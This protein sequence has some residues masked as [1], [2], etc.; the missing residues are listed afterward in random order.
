MPCP[1]PLIWDVR[2]TVKSPSM[3]TPEWH[4]TAWHRTPLQRLK[5]LQAGKQKTD[6][7]GAAAK[8]LSREVDDWL[9]LIRE[10]DNVGRKTLWYTH[11]HTKRSSSSTQFL[12]RMLI[13]LVGAAKV[14]FTDKGGFRGFRLQA[15]K[16]GGQ[17]EATVW[18][19]HEELGWP[20]GK[21]ARAKKL[22]T[23]LKELQVMIR[24][25]WCARA[26]SRGTVVAMDKLMG[27][28]G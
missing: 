22:E 6:A 7:K 1:D 27:T 10:T 13:S 4:P 2:Y 21:V 24:D 23:C 9:Y 12:N 25:K 26:G 3:Q 15:V 17:W 16:R 28:Y 14:H 19:G 8:A 18:P 5:F 11:L 20:E